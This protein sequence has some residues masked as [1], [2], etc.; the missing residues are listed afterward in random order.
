MA[1]DMFLK[2]DDIKGDSLD[3]T[4]KGEIDVTSWN[5]GVSQGGGAHAG[6]GSGTGKSQVADLVITKKVDRS[7]PLLFTMSCGGTP[8][9][10]GL[11]T[12]RKAGGTPLEYIKITMTQA[13]ITGVSVSLLS[14]SDDVIETV[15]LNFASFTYEYVPQNA[16]GSGGASIIKGYNIASNATS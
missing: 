6:P 15:S 7:S 4:H 9:T 11:L 12:L 2:L 14:G 1:V 5:W 16:D 8:I 10:T 13:L 3:T